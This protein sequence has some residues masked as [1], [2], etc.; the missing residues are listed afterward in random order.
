M[1]LRFYPDLTKFY[2]DISAISL[3]LCN[4]DLE[5]ANMNLVV[6]KYSNYLK[7]E[8]TPSIPLNDKGD[9][10][11]TKIVMAFQS[12]IQLNQFTPH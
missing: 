5:V 4:F 7:A 3:T 10:N 8:P 1:R 2:T 9:P 11:M 12:D 6:F